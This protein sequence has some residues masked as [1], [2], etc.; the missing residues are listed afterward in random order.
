MLFIEKKREYNILSSALQYRT[1]RLIFVENTSTL[2][3]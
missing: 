2:R 1:I 3:T